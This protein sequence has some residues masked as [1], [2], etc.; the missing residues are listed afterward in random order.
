MRVHES[1]GCCSARP[2]RRS[3]VCV[4]FD[5]AFGDSFGGTRQ[6][7]SLLRGAYAHARQTCHAGSVAA[8]CRLCLWPYV[9]C[10]VLGVFGVL[11][12]C[13]LCCG[14]RGLY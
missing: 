12:G 2:A 13:R 11:A 1:A 6:M 8:A 3:V 14:D 10:A 5:S 4:Y 9:V 7:Q